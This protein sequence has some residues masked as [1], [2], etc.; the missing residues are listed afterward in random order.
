MKPQK[1]I[2]LFRVVFIFFMGIAGCAGSN[3][4]LLFFRGKTVTIIVTN[5][6]GGMD[7]YARMVAPYL[8]KYLPGAKVEVKNVPDGGGII[9]RNEIYAAQPDGLT[10][11]FTT[12]AGALLA[13][14]AE[15][16]DVKYKTANFSYIGRINAEA[17][18]MVVS[19]K[20]G[21]KTLADVIRAG[22]I[23]M[24]FSGVGSDDYYMALI[25]AH[26]LGYQVDA[27]MGFMGINDASLACVRG[28][29]DAILF[30]ESS[31]QPQ[32]EAQTVV[33]VVSFSEQRTPVL[34]NVPTIFETIPPDKRALMQT[35][36]RI[37]ALDR[38][39]IAPPNMPAGRLNV[40]RTALDRAVAD[41]E[42]LENMAKIKRPVHYSSGADTAQLLASIM[43]NE[44]QIQPLV[45]EIA[46]N[47]H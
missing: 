2:S 33:P 30:S 8:Q 25:T 16:P 34:P 3:S 10:L 38:V 19:P 17:N 37:Y 22:K 29:V 13:E 12:S 28:D 32:I 47:S 5:G 7:T 23:S 26:I 31:V 15:Q 44:D 27:H 1:W 39:L 24:G 20:T 35:L 42:F 45:I 36:V 4:D 6:P 14:W 43:R 21:F 11:G 46:Q 18:I 9:G 40:L 41:P